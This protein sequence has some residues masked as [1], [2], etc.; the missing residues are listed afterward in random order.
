MIVGVGVGMRVE[1]GGSGFGRD[2]GSRWRR[3][4]GPAV[5]DAGERRHRAQTGSCAGTCQKMRM[6][7]AFSPPVIEAPYDVCRL[8]IARSTSAS[9]HVSSSSSRA[10]SSGTARDTG[11]AAAGWAGARCRSPSGW[12]CIV[13]RCGREA[14]RLMTRC[15]RHGGSRRRGAAEAPGRCGMRRGAPQRWGAAVCTWRARWCGVHVVH[16]VAHARARH[17]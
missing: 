17:H 2:E 5:S 16:M 15:V 14:R 12:D 3:G 10:V 13:W 9:P 8:S 11:A 6:C 1:G 7:G 4:C